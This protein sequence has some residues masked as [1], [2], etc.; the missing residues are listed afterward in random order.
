MFV[1]TGGWQMQSNSRSQPGHGDTGPLASSPD[2]APDS[3]EAPGA[4]APARAAALVDRAVQTIDEL[5]AY[6]G[7]ISEVS[8]RGILHYRTLAEEANSE[9]E[10]LQRRLSRLKADHDALLRETRARISDLEEKA[11]DQARE[12]EKPRAILWPRQGQT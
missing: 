11:R 3:P 1:S 2:H 8:G 4:L 10:D 7:N 6:A 5:I 12:L 9:A